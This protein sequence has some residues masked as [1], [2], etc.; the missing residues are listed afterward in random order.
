[1]CP[2]IPRHHHGKGVEYRALGAVGVLRVSVDLVHIRQ[3]V[4]GLDG[5]AELAADEGFEAALVFVG[6]DGAGGGAVVFEGP[7]DGVLSLLE[8]GAAAVDA[9]N[10]RGCFQACLYHTHHVSTSRETI[11]GQWVLACLP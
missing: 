11:T 4:G 8:H 1:M 6:E 3:G 10:D 5:G 9:V 7:G 2:L